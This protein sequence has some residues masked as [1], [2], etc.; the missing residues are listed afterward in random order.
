MRTHHR[1]VK[2]TPKPRATKNKSGELCGPLLFPLLLGADEVAAIWVIVEVADGGNDKVVDIW[3]NCDRQYD[4]QHSSRK[5]ICLPRLIV[6][7]LHGV[8]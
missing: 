6:S 2:T 8:R 5:T 3:A 4:D 7:I 1:F